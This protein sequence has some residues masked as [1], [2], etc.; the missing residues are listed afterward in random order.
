MRIVVVLALM[1]TAGCLAWIATERDPELPK[2]SKY[3]E[4]MQSPDRAIAAMA[5]AAAFFAG[6]LI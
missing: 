5:V 3:A 6:L 1:V 2:G 4:V